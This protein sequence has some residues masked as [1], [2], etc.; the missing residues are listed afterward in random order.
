MAFRRFMQAEQARYVE[1]I[2]ISAPGS[3][4]R[5]LLQRAFNPRHRANRLPA[6]DADACLIFGTAS[7]EL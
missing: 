7:V 1:P 2:R 4:D 3:S 5:I 6:T